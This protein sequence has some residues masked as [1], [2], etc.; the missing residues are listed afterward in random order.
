M[1]FPHYKEMTVS[2]TVVKRGEDYV[3]DLPD[4]QY[5][6]V[7]NFVDGVN[8]YAYPLPKSAEGKTCISH[9][10]YFAKDDKVMQEFKGKLGVGNEVTKLK[11]YTDI[12]KTTVAE[13]YVAEEK[14]RLT[15]EAESKGEVVKQED[16][17]KVAYLG[18]DGENAIPVWVFLR[19]DYVDR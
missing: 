11:A 19:K 5:G 15:A 1:L 3:P 17:D 6:L 2:S 4:L 9:V 12:V 7:L 18:A 13:K 16:L 8:H 14:A 10:I